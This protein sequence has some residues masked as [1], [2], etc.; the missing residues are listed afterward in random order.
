MTV[1]AKQPKGMYVIGSA[2]VF[3]RF[4]YYSLSFLLVLYASATVEKG[5]LGWTK[6]AS[7]SLMGYYTLAAFSL[8]VIGGFLAD[9]VIGTYRASIFG[10]LL[11]ILGH[12]TMFFSSANRLYLFYTALCMVASGTA[13]FKPSM[14]TLLGRLYTPTCLSREGGYKLYYMGINIGA[15]IAGF[16]GSYFLFHFGFRVALSVAAIGM[17]L[18]LIVLLLG[19]KH[20]V[21]D[22]S[23]FLKNADSVQ[24]SEDTPSAVH[25]KAFG[26][27]MLSF[28]FFA[29][30]A[31]IYNIATSG[32]LSIYIEY[33]TQ[34]N[35]LGFELQT[36]MFQS[37][38]S[39]GIVLSTPVFNSIFNAM[40]RR[41]RP[42]H[43]FTQM[44]FS[45]L[46]IFLGIAYF[47]HLSQVV[48]HG[49]PHGT[50]PFS[51]VGISFFI[52]AVSVSE[53]LISPVMMSAV[54]LF[55][56][57]KYKTLFQAFYLTV[58][59]VMGLVAGKVGAIS[60]SHPYKT[61]SALTLLTFAALVVF[62]LL[63][64]KMVSIAE[65]AALELHQKK[66]DRDV[67]V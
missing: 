66:E 54:S 42:V 8:P 26:Y 24:Q 53:V 47:T 32:T 17:S 27:L 46:I 18:G 36:P 34:K 12:V 61:F 16:S 65:E 49:V 31:L 6:E 40:V 57:S 63:R 20:L 23:Q 2:E 15:F 28:V 50:K 60:L 51:W 43:F 67:V 64:G 11:I 33:Y 13:F 37:L 22:D 1:I 19:K 52:L 35:V 41:G 14:P 9:K 29:V 55:S 38:E 58:I 39:I 44:N 21:T 3:E 5:G 25:K 48:E 45:L 56:P 4:S 7:L 59:G 30:W 62:T 10:G